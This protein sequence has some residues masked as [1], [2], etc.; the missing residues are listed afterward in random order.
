MSSQSAFVKIPSWH[1]TPFT[2]LGFL[3]NRNAEKEKIV[4]MSLNVRQIWIPE[5]IKKMLKL[6]RVNCQ[7]SSKTG[8]DLV[9]EILRNV[10]R[11][12]LHSVYFEVILDHKVILVTFGAIITTL[13]SQKMTK[14]IS[15]LL[16]F[17][18]NMN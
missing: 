1:F 13:D 3:A 11:Y 4:L 12:E 14:V 15:Q 9:K 7:L 17:G 5:A 6:N 10:P 2:R 18:G 8:A 16:N